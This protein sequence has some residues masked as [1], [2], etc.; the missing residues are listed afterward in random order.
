MSNLTLNTKEIV[1]WFSD[2]GDYTH[3]ITYDLNENSIIMDLGG[4][5]GV[6]AQQMIEKYNPYVYILEPV[7]NFY[8][9]MLSKFSNNNKVSLLNVG[10]GIEN[11]NGIILMGGDGTSSNLT[12]G[13]PINV[14][15]NT[16]ETILEKFKLE[17]VDL[18]Q[19]N[20]EGD[21][22]P[23][24]EYMLK[25]GSINKFKNI[26]IQFHLGVDN[27]IK[28]RNDIRDGLT[29][30]NFKIKFDYPFVWESWSKNK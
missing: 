15:F 9:G 23:L 22:Y 5:T 17:E 2:R 1:K 7:P 6:W 8:N 13:E 27:D 30:N 26:Q 21:E 11:K 14:Q 25:N 12:T 3:N 19:I 18:I 10:V 28:R 24:L 4:Y 16:I 29:K 20:I